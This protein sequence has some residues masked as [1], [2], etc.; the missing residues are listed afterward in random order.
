M[1]DILAVEG[2]ERR[3]LGSDMP[4]GAV[5]HALIRGFLNEETLLP[6]T[7]VTAW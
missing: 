7:V 1:V 5:K 4:R 2:D 3:L 6:E